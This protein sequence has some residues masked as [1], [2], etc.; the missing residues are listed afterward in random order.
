[1]KTVLLLVLFSIGAERVTAQ[2]T[3][4]TSQNIWMDFGGGLYAQGAGTFGTM[5]DFGVHLHK[6]THFFK[7][8][9]SVANEIDFDILGDS[10]HE[11]F[12]SGVS[13]MAGVFIPEKSL[14]VYQQVPD[15]FPDRN[16]I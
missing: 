10:P 1:M 14:C 3:I 16:T 15:L 6:N 11:Y 5:F 12:F 2:E 4:Y 7:I 9:A 8:R 13:N